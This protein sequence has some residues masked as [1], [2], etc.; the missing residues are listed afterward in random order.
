MTPRIALACAATSALVTAC[1]VAG[2]DP[3]PPSASAL[4]RAQATAA[5]QP[6]PASMPQPGAQAQA[7]QPPAAAPRSPMLA[8]EALTDSAITQRIT[9]ALQSD[10]GMKGADVS[11]NTDKGVV[12]LS[13]K[14][15]SH[16]QTGLASAHAQRQDGVLRV[17]NHLRPEYS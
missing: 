5:A 1:G 15:Q 11:I 4:E 13:G 16:E 9:A 14:V 12:V 2:D 10:P 3:R 6:A 7:A 8:A 17:D